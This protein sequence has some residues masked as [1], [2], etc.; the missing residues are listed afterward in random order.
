VLKPRDLGD[1][2]REQAARF[3]A[4]DG[5]NNERDERDDAAILAGV[6]V[7]FA[8]AQ[9]LMPAVLDEEMLHRVLAN[10]LRNGAQAIRDARRGGRLEVSCRPEKGAYVIDVDD[11]GPG[12]PAEVAQQLFDPYVTTKRDG[13]GLGLSIVKKVVVDHG[14]S[15]EATRSPLGGARFHVVLPRDGSEDAK[16]ALERA[17]PSPESIRAGS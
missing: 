8:I 5:M 16:A 4:R 3:E 14:G 9:D 2:L 12:I 15:I 6:T 7:S 10:L 11:D 1:F 17:A 13:T